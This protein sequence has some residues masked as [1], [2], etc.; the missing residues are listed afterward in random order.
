MAGMS[1]NEEM[2]M[3]S[4]L[5]LFGSWEKNRSSSLRSVMKAGVTS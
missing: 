2:M 1:W 4:A 5:R 3:A